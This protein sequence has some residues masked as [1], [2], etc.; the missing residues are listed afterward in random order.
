MNVSSNR[1]SFDLLLLLE[2]KQR[3]ILRYK[4]LIPGV[5]YGWRV[6][7]ADVD[8]RLPM[9][10]LWNRGNYEC[11]KERQPDHT[12]IDIQDLALCK[13]STTVSRVQAADLR[14]S[15]CYSTVPAVIQIG[16]SR[17]TIVIPRTDH[18]ASQYFI[19]PGVERSMRTAQA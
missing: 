16:I 14:T 12:T 17:I 18:P 4:G 2:M 15:A 11:H 9:D 6:H 5:I 7:I 1:N 10:L 8:A 3:R 13:L 19:H